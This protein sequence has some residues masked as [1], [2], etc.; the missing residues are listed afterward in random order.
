MTP[1]AREH[2]EG[3]EKWQDE[4]ALRG[5]AAEVHFHNAL[6]RHIATLKGGFRLARSPSD[7]AGIYGRPRHGATTWNP[8]RPRPLRPRRT[9]HLCGDEEATC[10]GQRP[11]TSLQVLHAGH[12]SVGTRDSQT[13]RGRDP[14]SVD[15]HQRCRRRRALRTRDHALVPR[16]R[17]SCAP[18]AATNVGAARV[19][20]RAPHPPVAALTPLPR[21]VSSVLPDP[22][23]AGGRTPPRPG[24]GRS[25]PCRS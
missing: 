10:R 24:T 5:Q 7:L 22:A 4:A 1:A 8:A 19:S 15:L 2:L 17:R 25:P 14:V 23:L 13:A 11:R 21:R 3:R 9:S 6:S 18:V 20:L 16:R 12:S